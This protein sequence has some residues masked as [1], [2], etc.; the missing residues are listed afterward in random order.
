MTRSEFRS[1]VFD[2]DSGKCVV[3]GGGGEDAHHI[4]DRK[5]FEGG[6]YELGNGATVCE[7]CHWKCELTAVSPQQLH[8]LAGISDPVYPESV[9]EMVISHDSKR[10]DKWL[11]E[12]TGQHTQYQ[13]RQ[14]WLEGPLYD[15]AFQ[16]VLD[17]MPW[18]LKANKVY[19]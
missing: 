1:A 7:N 9:G 3:C 8:E 19:I 13:G 5:L 4:F 16:R 17:Q 11:N 6:G 18:N 14:I 15:S 2:R 10:Y 12:F